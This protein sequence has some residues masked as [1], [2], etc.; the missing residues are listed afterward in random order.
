MPTLF[1]RLQAALADRYAIEREIGR[2]GMATVFLAQDLRHKRPVAVKVLAPDIGR[3]VGPDRFVREIEIAAQLTHPHILP[4]FES[5]GKDGWRSAT[6][7]GSRVRWQTRSTTRIAT[8]SYTAI[9]SPRTC[10]SRKGT[11]SSPTSG[12]PA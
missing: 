6:R 8:A 5:G 7:C 9:S 10:Y 11:P 3:T 1:E 12:S 4:M 2:G